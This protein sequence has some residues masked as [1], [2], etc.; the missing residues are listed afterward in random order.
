MLNWNNMCDPYDAGQKRTAGYA[1]TLL[2]TLSAK[3]E[4]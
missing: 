3:E 1:V 4:K 2:D